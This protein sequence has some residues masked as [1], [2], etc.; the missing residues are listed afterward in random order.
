[1]ARFLF[2]T[3]PVPGHVAP[4]APVASALVE[5]GHDV[6]WYT[7][8]SFRTA[9]ERT[10]ATHRPVVAAPDFGDGD[11]DRHFPDRARYTGLRQAI[12]DFERIFVNATEG[13]VSDLRAL[14]AEFGPDVLVTDPAVIAGFVLSEVDDLPTATINVS[15]LGLPSRDHAPFGLGLAPTTSGLGAVRNRLLTWMSDHVI[16]RKPNAAYRRIATRHGWPVLPIRPMTGRWLFIQPSVESFEYP[17]PDLP[18]Q[19]HFVG[20]LLPAGPA[21][22]LPEWR[23]DVSAA[24]AAGRRVVLVTQGTIATDPADLLQPTLAALAEENLLVLAAGIDP[25]QL[26]DLSANARAASFVPFGPLMPHIDAFVTNGGYG[27]VMIALASGVPVVAAGTTEDKAEVGGRLA[28]SGAG[29]S[30][31]TNRPNLSAVRDAVRMVLADPT[32]RES[33]RRIAQDLARHDGPA[34]AAALLETLAV[35]R[36]PVLCAST[37]PALSPDAAGS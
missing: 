24:R 37:R 11:Y 10:G 32:Y 25:A 9:V 3:V 33:A 36:A 15:V 22:A 27:G 31:R 17:R 7:S 20:P 19:V 4:I 6:V 14:A 23:D 16:F 2:A 18:P 13:Q 21:D 28:Y 35:T 1:M 26:P 34:E 29:I 30:L 5:R 8:S 12:Y